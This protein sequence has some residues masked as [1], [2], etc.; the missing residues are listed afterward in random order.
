MEYGC[1]VYNPFCEGKRPLASTDVWFL[2]GVPN[3]VWFYL[4]PE[5]CL[6]NFIVQ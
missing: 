5:T 3:C 4:T 2:E 1:M 6:A